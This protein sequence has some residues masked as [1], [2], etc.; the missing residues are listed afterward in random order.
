[1]KITKYFSPYSYARKLKKVLN[2]E[3][4]LDRYPQNPIFLHMPS[5]GP[6]NAITQD[7]R[8]DFARL[9]RQVVGNPNKRTYTSPVNLTFVTYS[10]YPHKTLIEQ[11]YD[12][13][14]INDYLVVGRE[15]ADWTWFSK[16]ICL[17]ESLDGGSCSS[18]WVVVT[19]ATD[20]VL[21]NDPRNIIDHFNSQDC[22]LLFCNTSVDWPPDRRCREFESLT[23]YTR[24]FHAHLNAGGLIG[25][26]QA[27]SEFL[28]EI[29]RGYEEKAPWVMYR[30]EFDDQ[31]A[32]RHLH[33]EHY[34]RIKVDYL[35][36][37]FKRFD[38]YRNMVYS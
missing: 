13:Y 36:L 3:S 9:C 8:R 26:R 35:S 17:R 6:T 23:Y 16:I 21:I 20:V 30:G 19:D 25:R 5:A 18:D 22:E 27:L 10:N 1:M 24:Q 37:I 32:W 14:G 31:L 29:I 28:D 12:A 4:E 15:V 34:P 2:P 38:I 33:R 7:V 11:C